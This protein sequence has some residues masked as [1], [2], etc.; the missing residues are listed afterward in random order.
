MLGGLVVEFL[1]PIESPELESLSLE[2]SSRLYES[3]TYMIAAAAIRTRIQDFLVEVDSGC[4]LPS[5]LK[6]ELLEA[7][8]LSGTSAS[9]FS[10]LDKVYRA[11][12]QGLTQQNPFFADWLV[13]VV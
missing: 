4:C 6:R 5:R 7:L 13:A 2:N 9:D 3:I 12:C 10:M 8:S 11:S 1:V